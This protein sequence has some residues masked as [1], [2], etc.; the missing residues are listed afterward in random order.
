MIIKEDRKIIEN[1]IRRLEIAYAQEKYGCTG[2][3]STEKT[4]QKY[5]VLR[6]ALENFLYDRDKDSTRSAMLRYQD[7]LIR[8]HRKVDDCFRAGDIRD[9]AY[10]DIV[11]ILMEG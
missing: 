11:R 2:S 7:Q 1:E 4:M 6:N 9:R 8:A 5:D 3:P 10:A